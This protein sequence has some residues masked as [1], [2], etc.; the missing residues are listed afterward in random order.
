M[1]TVNSDYRITPRPMLWGV[2]VVW[3]LWLVMMISSDRWYLFIDNWFMSV[4][5]MV[6]SFIAGAT[7]EGGG[8]VA[9]PV[10][11]LLFHIPP[12][13]ARDFA[14]MIQSVGMGAAAFTIIC[15]K[16]PV[17]WRAVVFA[18]LGGAIGIIVGIEV[19]SP[20][21]AAPYIKTFFT[22]FWLSFAIV[23]FCTNRRRQHVNTLSSDSWTTQGLLLSV[24]MIGGMVSGLTGSGLDIVTFALLVLGF[25]ISEKIATPTSVVLMA[26]NAMVGFAWKAS[27]IATPLADQAWLYWYVC[28]PIVVIGAPLGA[29]FIS[30]RSRSLIAAFLYG[31]IVVQYCLAWLILPQTP[32]LMLFNAA[33]LV[34]GISLFGYI[35]YQGR[36]PLPVPAGCVRSV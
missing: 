3:T 4:T 11:T 8:A 18:G 30:Q 26:S 35:A 17:V 23:L 32:S 12:A 25:N 21:F 5:M 31:S 36:R 33:S 6:G 7:S 9:F 19:L 10:M 29:L 34:L 1:K 2:G 22:C 15:L 14:L 16:I 28:I 13:I 20:L 24:G 27:G